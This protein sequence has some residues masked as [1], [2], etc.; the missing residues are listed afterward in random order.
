MGESEKFEG[1]PEESVEEN[2]DEWPKI[3]EEERER[4]R[5]ALEQCYMEQEHESELFEKVE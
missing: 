3:M 5:E 1:M 2:W 4:N